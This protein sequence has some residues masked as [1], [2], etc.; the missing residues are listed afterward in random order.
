MF[1]VLV[2]GGVVVLVLN[3]YDSGLVGFGYEVCVLKEL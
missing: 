1:G 2:F 3:C